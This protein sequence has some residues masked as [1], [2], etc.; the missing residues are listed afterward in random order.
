MLR[1]D[2]RAGLCRPG[3][4]R[5]AD[6]GYLYDRHIIEGLRHLGRKVKVIELGPYNRETAL[7]DLADGA[8]T[9]IDGLALPALEQAV[10]HHGRRLRLVTLVHHPLAEETRLSGAAAERLVRLEAA[11]LPRFRGVLWPSSGTAAA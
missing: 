2:D 11:A 4:A 8:T 3:Q 5:P 7:A 6:R 10:V 1:S 9:V